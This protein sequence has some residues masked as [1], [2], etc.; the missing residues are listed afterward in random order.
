MLNQTQPHPKFHFD[1]ES[2]IYRIDGIQKPGTTSILDANGFISWFAKQ[3]TEAMQKG[4]DVHLITQLYDQDL[5]ESYP[6][7][8]DGHLH[9][10]IQF[11]N[12][13]WEW[14]EV[15]RPMWDRERELWCGMLDRAGYAP[16]GD[17][18]IVDIYTGVVEPPYKRIQTISYRKLLA[19]IRPE[20]ANAKRGILILNHD[21]TRLIECPNDTEDDAAWISAL[22]LYYWKLK[23][24]P[25]LIAA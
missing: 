1:P 3:S 15:E 16:N 23:Y 5:L 22:N 18:W 20:Y 6:E 14:E 4:S 19:Q 24:S 9:Q 11:C 2:H 8:Y 12:Q 7:K 10:W 25:N 13:G 17:R 21:G